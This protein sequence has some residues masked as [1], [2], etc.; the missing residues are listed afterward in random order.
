MPPENAERRPP[1]RRPTSATAFED[2]TRLRRLGYIIR[3]SRDPLGARLERAG[4]RLRPLNRQ[5]PAAGHRYAACPR[6][7]AWNGLWIDP[8]GTW[9]ALCGCAPSGGLDAIDLAMF[10]AGAP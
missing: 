7:E 3:R 5:R 1:R 6:C 4:R 2:T 8:D 10:L 9:G